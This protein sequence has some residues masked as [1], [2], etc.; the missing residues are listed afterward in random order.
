MLVPPLVSQAAGLLAWKLA[1]S[2]EVAYA[3]R[4]QLA[5]R[6]FAAYLLAELLHSRSLP[7]VERT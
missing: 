5:V 1:F 7:P 4:A 6:A 3:E 2:D